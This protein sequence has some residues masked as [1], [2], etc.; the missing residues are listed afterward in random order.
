L[1]GDQKST[2]RKYY[3]KIRFNDH[4]DLYQG[5]LSL[6]QPE[7]LEQALI[8]FPSSI[9]LPRIPYEFHQVFVS[10]YRKE[11]TSCI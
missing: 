4:Y 5:A 6:I 9:S 8:D 11:L 2:I 3:H 10:R 1:F 7:R